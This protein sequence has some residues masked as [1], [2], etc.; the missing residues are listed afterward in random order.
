M[1]DLNALAATAAKTKS[2]DDEAVPVNEEVLSGLPFLGPGLA[3]LVTLQLE[4]SAAAAGCAVLSQRLDQTLAALQAARMVL[5]RRKYLPSK[6]WREAAADGATL[7]A[8]ARA[9]RMRRR[10]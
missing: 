10:G 3:R 1:V 6:A 8:W 5:M 7:A 9:V 4:K 2:T